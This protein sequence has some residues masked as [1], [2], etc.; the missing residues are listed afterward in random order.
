MTKSLVA[1]TNSEIANFD[2]SAFDEYADAG[3]EEV[4]ARDYKIPLLKIVEPMGDNLKKNNSKFIQGAK[5]GDIVDTAI[6]E[7]VGQSVLFLPVKFKKSFIEWQDKKIVDRHSED[8][9]NLCEW[10]S[11][12]GQRKGNFRTD[13][14]NEVSETFEF[15]GLNLSS[16]GNP[17]VCVS[18]AR[19][20]VNAAKTFLSY[21]SRTLLPNGKKAPYFYKV[22]ELS[23]VEETKNDDTFNTWGIKSHG[24]LKDQE[25]GAALFQQAIDFYSLLNEG[26]AVAEVDEETVSEAEEGAM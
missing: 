20:R 16:E 1:K 7:V 18:M 11:I 8:I 2:E 4:T 25:Q 26:R 3:A 9:L 12:D 19:G 15:Y 21:L 13:N 5:P 23:T 14:G 17:W 6:N 24:F 22:W 10:R